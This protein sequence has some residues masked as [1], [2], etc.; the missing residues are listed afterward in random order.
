M[1][2]ILAL[3]CCLVVGKASFA[4][5]DSLAFD[6]KGKYIYYKVV[7]MDTYSADTLYNR[8]LHFFEGISTD[9][10][11]TLTQQDAKNAVI[12]GSG[13]FIVHKQSLAKHPDGQVAY[14]LKMEIKEGKYRFWLTNLTYRPYVRD[15]YT[16]YVADKNVDF[17]LEKSSKNITDKDLSL[18]LDQFATSARQ[19]GDKL[20]KYVSTQHSKVIKKELEKKVIHIDKW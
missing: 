4:Q 10:T 17:A 11:F 16:N 13:F 7:N 18:F 9:K 1:N 6:D 15:R 2:K 8:S 14:L 12:S 3:I 5:K 20:K 19:L